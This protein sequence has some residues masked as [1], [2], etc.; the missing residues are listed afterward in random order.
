MRLDLED[1]AESVADVH[2]AGVLL[3][4]AHADG[5]GR[6]GEEAKQRFGVLVAAVLAPERAEEAE[7]QR[8]G[9]A[10]E[11]LDDQLVLAPRQR[12]LI[13]YLLRDGHGYADTP[14][15]PTPLTMSTAPS[16]ARA[17]IRSCPR[18]SR[19]TNV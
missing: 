10:L 16:S 8:V 15:N 6:G 12:D 13:E 7:L 11:A 17:V 14:T 2:H 5:I 1:D 9:L 18:N 4:G 3:P 19:S